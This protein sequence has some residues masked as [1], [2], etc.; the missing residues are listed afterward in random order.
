[1]I[2]DQPLH[3]STQRHP[4]S[5]GEPI[6]YLVTNAAVWDGDPR[7]LPQVVKI[8]TTV[9]LPGRMKRMHRS[10]G[11]RFRAVLFAWSPG[12]D[13]LER[14]LH[15]RHRNYRVGASGD[16]FWVHPGLLDDVSYLEAERAARTPMETSR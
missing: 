15:Y 10:R 7:A 16:W 3:P 12:G 14:E 2:A 4:L 1:M 6:V 9:D 13:S 5:L 11:P 8:G